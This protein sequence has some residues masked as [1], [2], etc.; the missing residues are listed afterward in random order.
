[1]Y[2]VVKYFD[3]YYDGV[4]KENLTKEEADELILWW[5]KNCKSMP[6]TSYEIRPM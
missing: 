6:Y 3:D 5:R 2:K 4:V 1:M